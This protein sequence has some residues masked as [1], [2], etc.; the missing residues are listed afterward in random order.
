MGFTISAQPHQIFYYEFKL[1][2]S[3]LIYKNANGS[4]GITNSKCNIIKLESI[5]DGRSTYKRDISKKDK[6]YY[7]K[8]I[9]EAINKTHHHIVNVNKH[10]ISLPSNEIDLIE[11]Y[12]GTAWEPLQNITIW[13][14]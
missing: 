9:S 11:H 8:S 5:T 2:E 6:N 7:Y 14:Q 13:K 10:N 4:L 1:Q 3:L 12:N